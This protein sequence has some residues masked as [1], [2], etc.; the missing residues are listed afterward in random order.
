[1]N[2]YWPKDLMLRSF[3]KSLVEQKPILTQFNGGEKLKL[4]P[5]GT[6]SHGRGKLNYFVPSQYSN[7]IV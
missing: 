5:T 4:G 6:Y 3:L 2:N 1:M 7:Y